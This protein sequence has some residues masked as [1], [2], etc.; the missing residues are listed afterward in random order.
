MILTGLSKKEK[1]VKII[2][3]DGSDILNNTSI[4]LI[5]DN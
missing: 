4:S 2:F 1:Y 5:S 3:W